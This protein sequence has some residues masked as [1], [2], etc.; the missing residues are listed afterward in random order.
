MP[1]QRSTIH[2]TVVCDCPACRTLTRSTVTGECRCATCGRILA[3][4]RERVREGKKA[5]SI[6][7]LLHPFGRKRLP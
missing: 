6:R 7:S 3:V 5:W 1:W 2:E 4:D